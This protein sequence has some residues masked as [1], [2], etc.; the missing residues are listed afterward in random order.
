MAGHSIEE[1]KQETRGYI[2]VFVALAALT[3]VT[4]AVSYL[5]LSMGPAIAVAMA[6][7]LLKGS[8]VACFFM[9]LISEQKLVYSVLVLTLVFFLV[10]MLLPMGAFLDQLGV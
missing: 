7:A 3:I 6:I 2:M 5:D 10:L 1:I 8:L 9:H 4:V